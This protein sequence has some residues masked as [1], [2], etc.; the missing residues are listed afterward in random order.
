MTFALILLH[1]LTLIYRSYYLWII[2]FALGV[3]FESLGV[4]EKVWVK[5]WADH[6][7]QEA[8]SSSLYHQS[9]L[10]LGTSPLDEQS[11]LAQ[12]SFN[13]GHTIIQSMN[14]SLAQ[15]TS[16]RIHIDFPS[17]QD[18]PGFYI[19]VY[20]M[21]GLARVVISTLLLIVE[22]YGA[23]RASK[24]LFRQLLNTVVGTTMRWIDTTPSGRYRLFGHFFQ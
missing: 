13:L 19:G 16:A 20:G 17:A 23:F 12:S 15:Q 8:I 4:G 7:R 3:I 11:R 10:S 24:V 21:I 18:R 14:S 22:Y 5:I 1:E 2:I 9:A 6:Y